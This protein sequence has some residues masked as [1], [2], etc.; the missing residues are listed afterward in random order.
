ML[1]VSI[2]HKSGGPASLFSLHVHV[3][4]C[5]MLHRIVDVANLILK[6]HLLC[7]FFPVTMDR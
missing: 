1:L 6:E 3:M 4:M 5:Y 2:K 7:F